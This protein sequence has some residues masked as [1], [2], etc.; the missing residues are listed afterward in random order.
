MHEACRTAPNSE[1]GY[2]DPAGNWQLRETLAAYL[3]RVR[4]ADTAADRVIICS[5]MAQSVALILRV[6]AGQG[7]T[8]VG[9]EDPGSVSSTTAAAAWAGIQAVPV[10]VDD[11]GVDVTALEASGAGAV[12]LTPAHQWPTGVVLAPERRL[13]LAD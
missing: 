13:A 9:F 8:R 7:L 10:R 6:L 11:H 1:L 4:A 5:G 2:G 12:L 3:R